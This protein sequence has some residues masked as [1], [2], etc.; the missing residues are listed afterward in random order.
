MQFSDMIDIRSR[1]VIKAHGDRCYFCVILA[2]IVRRESR[3]KIDLKIGTSEC[4]S[5]QFRTVRTCGAEFCSVSEVTTATS[6]K[7]QQL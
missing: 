5:T 6:L 1:I 3:F 2:S 7:V 4:L